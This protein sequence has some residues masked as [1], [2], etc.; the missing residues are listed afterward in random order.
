M[1]LHVALS[2]ADKKRTVDYV[3]FSKRCSAVIANMVDLEA[4]RLNRDAID[5]FRRA[6]EYSTFNGMNEVI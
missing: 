4:Q 6:D 2:V 3:E 1:Q 5:E